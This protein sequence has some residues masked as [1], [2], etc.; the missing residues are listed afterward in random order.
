[1]SKSNH[2]T[3]IAAVRRYGRKLRKMD[4]EQERRADQVFDAMDVARESEPDLS[5]WHA[6]MGPPRLSVPRFIQR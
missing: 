1:M 6:W 2:I 3:G 5:D 4:A